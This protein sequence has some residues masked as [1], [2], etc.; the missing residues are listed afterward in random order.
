MS[1]IEKAL[2][3]SKTPTFYLIYYQNYYRFE[4][5]NSNVWSQNIT[6]SGKKR[7]SK[8]R[9]VSFCYV[10]FQC[11]LGTTNYEPD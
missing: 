2:L 5:T 10:V 4:L 3:L 9:I 1:T 6:K 11:K 7:Q 8:Q